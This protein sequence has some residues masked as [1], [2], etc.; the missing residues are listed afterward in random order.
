MDRSSKHRLCVVTVITFIWDRSV[1]IASYS[2]S[3]RSRNCR[4]GA[5][6]GHAFD[7]FFLLSSHLASRLYSHPP[8][9]LD[10]RRKTTANE[11]LSIPL[12]QPPAFPFSSYLFF[13]FLYTLGNDD[14]FS[15]AAAR[16]SYAPEHSSIDFSSFSLTF[17]FFSFYNF[18][19]R[20]AQRLRV[21]LPIPDADPLTNGYDY[22][23]VG[24]HVFKLPPRRGRH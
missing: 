5:P 15:A 17:S 11:S 20:S 6:V 4:V 8:S 12:S 24:T 14:R 21:Y 3:D 22:Q 19:E 1:R 9:R 13:S 18:P 2:R 10:H 23:S 16:H 7:A